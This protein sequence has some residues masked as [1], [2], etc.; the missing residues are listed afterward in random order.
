MS[1]ASSAALSW[2][3][4]AV[5]D[6]QVRQRQRLV[7]PA[8]EVAR[9]DLVD[10]REV[11]LLA[12]P[13]DL[14]LAVLALLRP[15]RLEPDQRADR[16]PAL[17]VARCR[18]RRGSAARRSG[19]GR[20]PARTPGPRPAPRSRTTRCAGSPGGAARCD[21][22]ARASGARCRA[23]GPSSRRR[24]GARAARPSL[25]AETGSP[26]AAPA[27]RPGRSSGPGRRSAPPASSSSSSPSR[28]RCSRP[29]TRP[30]RTRISTPTASSPSRA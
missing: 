4:P 15:A 10:R 21:R 20:V 3:L 1:I 5:D 8:C 9:D 28:N 18:R 17:V 12:Q 23:A 14:E 19:P 29:T 27:P 30:S 24:A 7:P 16:V 11:V 2:P 22:P 25:P 13:L 26:R 6:D